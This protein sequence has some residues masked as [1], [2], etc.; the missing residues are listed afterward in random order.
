MMHPSYTSSNSQ[1]L[2]ISD[3]D[4]NNDIFI[5]NRDGTSVKQITKTPLDEFDPQYVKH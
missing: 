1:I 2:F 5:M 3:K 4:G